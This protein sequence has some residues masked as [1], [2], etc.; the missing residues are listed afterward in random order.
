MISFHP[1]LL[2]A[3]SGFSFFP[4]FF[5]RRA[6]KGFFCQLFTFCALFADHPCVAVFFCAACC[7]LR[8]F[9][10][11]L[12]WKHILHGLRVLLADCLRVCMPYNSTPLP[13]SVC[14]ASF[15]FWVSSCCI[16]FFSLL[17][18]FPKG[19]CGC[20]WAFCFLWQLVVFYC[21]C[22]LADR[23]I[24]YPLFP[25]REG[26]AFFFRLETY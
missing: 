14:L 23:C 16:P 8:L 20:F 7:C 25:F 3:Y 26:F 15:F 4:F 10:S 24:I 22:I 21:W 13:P 1:F 9:P 19:V 5:F 17:L 18:F 2:A 12:F 6:P 11:A